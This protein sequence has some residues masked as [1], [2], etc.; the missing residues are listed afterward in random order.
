MGRLQTDN[1]KVLK[2]LREMAATKIMNQLDSK[3]LNDFFAEVGIEGR[4][5][6]IE[7]IHLTVRPIPMI[8]DNT[9]M[10]RLRGRI[11][12]NLFSIEIWINGRV[13]MILLVRLKLK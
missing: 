12:E 11:A 10:D 2:D 7:S 8:V 5:A 1:D 13:I 6:L 9:E 4:K 3:S